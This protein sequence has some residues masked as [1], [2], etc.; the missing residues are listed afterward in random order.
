[1][2]FISPGRGFRFVPLAALVAAFAFCSSAQAQQTAGV[3]VS[4]EGILSI[5]AVDDPGGELLAEQ[6]RSARANL[7]PKVGAR[8][9]LR[10]ISLNRLQAAIDEQ[11]ASG[12]EVT[13]DMK[14]LAGLTRI[15]YVFFYPDSGDIVISGP[16]EGWFA[17]PAGRMRGIDSGL[18]MIELQDLLVA[19]RAF[20]PGKKAPEVVGC[21]IDPT[22]EGEKRLMDFLNKMGGR[23]T[24]RDTQF[25][26]DGLR[27]SLG[28]QSVTVH[29]VPADT[30]FAQI[31]VEAD[32]R[33]KLVG[34][35]LETPPVPIKS[36]VAYASA[37]QVSRN[38]LQRW[39]F[40]P[41]YECVRMTAD[42]HG[43]EIV[44]DGVKLI[45]EDEFVNDAGQ[46][47]AKGTNNKASQQFV[48]TF[49]KLYPDLAAKSPVYA[50]LRNLV[51]MLVAAAYIQNQ[52]LYGKAGFEPTTFH[53]ES[54]LPTRVCTTPKQVETAVNAI[55]KG[56]RL[57]TPLG[58]GVEIEASEALK[59][60]N[61]LIDDQ[62]RVE[63]QRANLSVQG[64]AKG[65]W[66]WD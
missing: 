56:N 11:L 18:P 58:G 32:Y 17:D 3:A 15:Q 44:G 28:L 43:M 27:D 31:L 34:I 47:T 59:P 22:E 51:D 61:L 20:P 35:G 16:A 63:R 33:M 40:V 49:T 55:W 54:K 1:M 13:Q 7:D 12:R 21:S 38:A 50:Q 42:G 10:K 8:S 14:F 29:G 19:L 2:S 62:N 23:A 48:E 57:L 25:I 9:P 65:Q 5:F 66:W 36:Y 45:G 60:E 6:I 46:R 4:T 24:P 26:A 41:D 53:D 30:H 52:D 37:S 39:Y 64:L